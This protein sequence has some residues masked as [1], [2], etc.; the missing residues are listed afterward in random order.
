MDCFSAT[1]QTNN[2]RRALEGTSNMGRRKEI[3]AITND[4]STSL[5]T[6]NNDYNGYWTT[7]QLYK[8]ALEKGVNTV[9]IDIIDKK[10][11]PFSDEFEDIFDTYCKILHKQ[12]EARKLSFNWLES[13]ILKYTFDEIFDIQIHKHI[14]IGKPYSIEL[15]LISDMGHTY[16]NKVGGHCRPHDPTR[17][18]RSV[19]F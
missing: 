12:F 2:L 17:E 3:A 14:G 4:W 6:R 5:G 16:N 11:V 10:M 19:R 13:A 8:L 7:G 1:L 15:T 9:E 18:C